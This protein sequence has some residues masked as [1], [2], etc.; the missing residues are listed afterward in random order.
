MVQD[1]LLDYISSQMK[2]GVSRDA[3][4]SALVTA[5]WVSADVEDTLKKLEGSGA[6][7]M[8]P[9]SPSSAKPAQSASAMSA[10]A[11]PGEPQM[12]RVSDLVSNTSVAPVTSVTTKAT[13][14]SGIGM[15]KNDTTKFAGKISGNTFEAASPAMSSGS[16]GGKKGLIMGA[17]GGIIILGL[18][19]LAWYFYSGNAGLAAQVASL[20]SDSATVKAQLTTLQ[21]QLDASSTGFA[22]QIATLTD[23]NADLALNLSF[24]AA[25]IDG[26][27]STAAT[28]LSVTISGWL[29]GGGKAPYAITTPRGAKIF[30][31]NSAD[32][33]IGPQ[34]K[35]IV[36]HTV[37]LAGTYVPGSDE[38]TVSS[39]T[40]LT[41]APV[42]STT[43]ATATSTPS[44]ATSTT[45]A[46][47]TTPAASSTASSS[48]S[49]P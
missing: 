20:T 26:S 25:P 3:I 24:Y 19:G 36:G 2:L 11:K 22:A 34:L 27:S 44:A 31:L 30:V 6:T 41:P 32:A 35:P 12:I 28:P 1:Q 49:T 39:V 40:D 5:G 46:A 17:I 4:K 9:G 23:A 14:S 47:A 33:K 16:S 10:A 18:A 45:P 38:I 7:A 13:M 21:S 15:A 48:T 8:Q 43:P 29:S 37:Q 42:A